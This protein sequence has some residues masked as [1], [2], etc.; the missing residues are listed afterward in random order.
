M[1]NKES[2]A[3]PNENVSQSLCLAFHLTSKYEIAAV[4]VEEPLV[5]LP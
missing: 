4:E 1:K 5:D 3:Q 2:N